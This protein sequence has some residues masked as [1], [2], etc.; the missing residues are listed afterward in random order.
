MPFVGRPAA[1]LLGLGL[2]LGLG[3]VTAVAWS[4]HQPGAH[5]ER[6]EQTTAVGD[7]VYAPEPA[8]KPD[9]HAVVATL[10]G[11]PLV[12]W[13]AGKLKARDTQMT[14]AGQD[15]ARHLTIYVSREPIP[16]PEGAPAGETFYFVKTAS[17]EY[18][19][20]HAGR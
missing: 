10:N 7:T 4:D 1:A 15:P 9:P 5:T 2:L 13:S 19:R 3:A 16:A 14:P 11:Q 18:L 12:A 8:Q 20:L 17:N 6:F